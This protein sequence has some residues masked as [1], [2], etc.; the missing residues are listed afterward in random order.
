M[1]KK[2]ITVLVNSSA[3]HGA[4]VEFLS[5]RFEVTSIDCKENIDFIKIDLVLFT[6]GEDISPSFYG[7]SKGRYTSINEKRDSVENDYMFNRSG[8]YK[9]PKLGICRG[10]QFLTV[11]NGGKLIQHVSGHGLS[12]SH[13]LD[14]K[15]LGINGEFQITSTHHQMMFP[16]NLPKESYEILAT[17]THFLSNTYLDGINSEKELPK[18]FEE[19]EIVFYPNTKSL[20]IQGHPEYSNCPENT[21]EECLNL[22]ENYLRL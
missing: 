7:E 10:A 5:K 6:G 12:G 17:A 19:C 22:I 15:Y 13:P 9:V 21:V 1:S 18:N 14:M 3:G 11:M 20:C 16:Y 4:C 8:M 2:K